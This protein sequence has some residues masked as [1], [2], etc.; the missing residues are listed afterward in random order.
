LSG[1][2][3]KRS[4]TETFACDACWKEFVESRNR[5]EISDILIAH[6]YTPMTYMLIP[7]DE[8]EALARRLAPERFK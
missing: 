2:Q 3:D 5:A 8:R 4:V 7:L 6:G 1:Q